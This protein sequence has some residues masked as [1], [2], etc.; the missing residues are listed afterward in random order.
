MKNLKTFTLSLSLLS[1]Q[2]CYGSDQA[3]KAT[4]FFYF[5]PEPTP[6]I[7]VDLDGKITT[8][9]RY[10]NN[11][12]EKTVIKRIISIQRDELLNVTKFYKDGSGQSYTINK[13]SDTKS[14]VHE[15]FSDI[16]KF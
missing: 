13:D 3:I 14:N 11:R 2:L 8:T 5:A 10:E 4:S 12:L 9:Y 16:V 6:V 15:Y 1:F 7:I